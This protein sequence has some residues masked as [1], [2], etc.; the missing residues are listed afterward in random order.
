MSTLKAA[1]SERRRSMPANLA[2]FAFKPG[3]SGNPG[4]R[5][6][7][8][9]ECQRLAREV[10]LEST[11][12]LI[13]I[14]RQT[15]D[16]R[17]AIVASEALYRRAWGSAPEST[18]PSNPLENMTPEQRRKRL[19]EL[20]AYAET[21]RPKDIEGQTIEPDQEDSKDE[22]GNDRNTRSAGSCH[23]RRSKPGRDGRGGYPNDRYT[24]VFAR[25]PQN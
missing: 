18:V 17:A 6:V 3:R 20:F 2:P 5:T 1:K 25:R 4:G 16:L 22:T 10:S 19:L 9:A 21:L 15:H 14:M 24:A 8:Y 11:E 23:R 12:R 13:E 7:Q